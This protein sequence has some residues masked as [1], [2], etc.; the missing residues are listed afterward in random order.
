MDSITE[1]RNLLSRTEFEQEWKTFTDYF[2]DLI[3]K[4]KDHFDSTTYLFLSQ[5][6]EDMKNHLLQPGLVGNSGN[7]LGKK[8]QLFQ[9]EAFNNMR[10]LASNKRRT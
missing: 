8:V 1:N 3:K 2:L 9:S 5:S 6:L 7:A 10:D 4:S